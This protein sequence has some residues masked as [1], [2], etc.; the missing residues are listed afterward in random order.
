MYGMSHFHLQLNYFPKRLHNKIAPTDS[1]RRPDQ[2][3]LENGDVDNASTEK[4]RLENRQR[5][6]RT[7]YEATKQE[8][9]PTYFKEWQNPNDGQTYFVYNETYW[10]KDRA[11][12]DWSR[13]PDIYGDKYPE[14]VQ[15]YII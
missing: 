7:Y 4:S 1:R 13:C 11:N 5:T 10:E 9:R 15:P 6:Y 12:Q 14:E 8:P 2:R 3:M